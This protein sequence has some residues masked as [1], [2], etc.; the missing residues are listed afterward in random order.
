[1]STTERTDRVKNADEDV[2]AEDVDVAKELPPPPPL[3]S[4]VDLASTRRLPLF[5]TFPEAPLELGAVALLLLLL[6]SL[7]ENMLLDFRGTTNFR[8]RSSDCCRTEVSNRWTSAGSTS[9]P[10][11]SES[12]VAAAALR[13]KKLPVS[14]RS[15]LLMA[16]RSCS[17][18]SSS[19]LI[20][21]RVGSFE[22][23]T[24]GA[25]AG[26]DDLIGVRAALGSLGSAAS[27]GPAILL[28]SVGEFSLPLSPILRR[29]IVPPSIG[30]P[31]ATTA[32]T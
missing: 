18:S 2:A 32:C 27:V 6:L 25:G 17:S 16:A 15:E 29:I 20:P 13:A 10:L 30:A 21:C 12:S 4:L 11:P 14:Y 9:L 5:R 3:L 22:A 31:D 8:R 23:A 24:A 26:T 28:L 1:M 7:G 19:R